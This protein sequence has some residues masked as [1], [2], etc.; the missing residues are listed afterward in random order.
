V[1]AGEATRARHPSS[2]GAKLAYAKDLRDK[3]LAVA[4]DPRGTVDVVHVHDW[5]LGNVGRELRDRLS[6]PLVTTLHLL[7][8]PLFPRWGQRLGA[9]VAQ[10]EGELCRASDL[11]VTVSRAMADL[12]Q[13]TYGV[14]AGRVLAIH[15]GLDAEAVAAFAG[16]RA[17]DPD[18][19][20]VVFAS[21]ITRQK[22]VL[23]LL[24]SAQRVLEQIPS[25]RWV[26]AGPVV[27]PL[28]DRRDLGTEVGAL[29]ASDARLQ[30]AV[31]L[32]GVV[33]RAG[34][35]R[36]YREASLAVVPSVYEPFGYV[37]LEAMCAGVP[38][39]ASDAGGLSEIV[40]DGVTGLMVPVEAVPSG[41]HE[42]SV[43][44]LAEAQLRLLMNP[45]WARSIGEAGRVQAVARFPPGRMVDETAAAL[46]GVI[47]RH[48]AERTP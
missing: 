4:A 14:P 30:A 39:V 43:A 48:V 22:G 16:E 11:V 46:R 18:S 19:P 7:Y 47:D 20:L 42:P 26:L 8:G 41:E 12:V 38:V 6:A 32:P 24:R 13:S 34:L 1:G 44:A 3:A 29:L 10:A 27:D 15:N 37:A 2:R 25:A 17:P 23:P 31:T 36:L 5:F 21:R 33:S 45:A 40:E 28:R 35:A 9:E